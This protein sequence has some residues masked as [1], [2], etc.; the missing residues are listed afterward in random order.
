MKNYLFH[1]ANIILFL[2]ISVTFCSS[3]AWAG[4]DNKVGWHELN[5]QHDGKSRYFRYFI[6]SSLKA[7]P[8]LV[9]LFHGG[10]QSMRKIFRR[11][12]G[13]SQEWESLA[14][15]NGF[16]L[17]APNGTNVKTGD[18]KGN[19]QN[20]ND[21]RV[22]VQG[23]NSASKADDVGFVSK[24]IDWAKVN[25]KINDS[26]VYVTGASNGGLM[27]LRLMTELGDRIAAAAVFI[28][29]QPVQSDCAQPNNTVPL[30]L[31]L[32]TE[33]P[34]MLWQGGQILNE[35][36]VMMSASDTLDYWLNVNNADSG[37]VASEQL[38]DIDSDDDSVIF[39]SIYPAKAGGQPL[40]FY[41]VRG[42][43]HTTPSIKYDVPFF[44]RLL[45]GKQN[46]D[47]ESSHEAWDFLRQF[48]R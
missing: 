28:A 48:N 25:F 35:G 38:P 46:K 37:M 21:C 26:R 27:S 43:G 34:L 36:P 13:G 44:A 29:N 22:A 2:F 14:E 19:K 42:A 5:I 11:R 32:A 47:L 4:I 6:P 12:A 16:L 20:W 10:T 7:S 31:M 39:K 8:D 40:W 1:F 45:V 33:D 41:E 30:F 17:M 18:T 23:N 24:L 15:K 9:L 3:H